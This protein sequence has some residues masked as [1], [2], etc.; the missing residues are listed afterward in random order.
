M[1][2]NSAKTKWNFSPKKSNTELSY[3]LAIPV[4]G[5][6]PKEVQGRTQ[7]YICNSYSKQGSS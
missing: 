7:I 2:T 6:Y 5:I 4:L 3:D 1:A